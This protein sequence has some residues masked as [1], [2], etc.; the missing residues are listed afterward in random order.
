[1]TLTL[2]DIRGRTRPVHTRTTMSGLPPHTSASQDVKP[3]NRKTPRNA[4]LMPVFP[5]EI[6]DLVIDYLYL[7]KRALGACSLVCSQFLPASRCNLFYSLI[8]ED[9]DPEDFDTFNA[10]LRS[11]YVTFPPYVRYVS[12]KR[13]RRRVE[14]GHLSWMTPSGRKLWPDK[15]FPGFVNVNDLMVM[16]FHGSDLMGPPLSELFPSLNSLILS[17]CFFDSF[18]Q[19]IGVISPYPK[20]LESLSVTSCRW[21]HSDTPLIDLPSPPSLKSL[22]LITREDYDIISWLLLHEH[23][24]KDIHTLRLSARSLTPSIHEPFLKAVGASLRHL[25]LSVRSHTGRSNDI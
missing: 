12:V 7:D 9:L 3:T 23:A 17:D 25:A 10:L 5:P 18:S 13:K 8:L 15:L 1:M 11:P 14:Y 21:G 2:T 4:D 16:D 24:Y 19:F 22:C 6:F 20:T